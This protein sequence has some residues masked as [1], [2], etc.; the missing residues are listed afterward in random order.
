VLLQETQHIKYL[1][2]DGRIEYG[3]RFTMY[4]W[5]N[6]GVVPVVK[7]QHKILKMVIEH[8]IKDNRYAVWYN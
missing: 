3:D 2:I 8:V 7:M 4:I 6:K 5:H 1:K